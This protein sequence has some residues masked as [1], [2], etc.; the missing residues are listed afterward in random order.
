MSIQ[1]SEISEKHSSLR[2]RVELR[3]IPEPNSGCWLWE[4]IVSKDGY[5]IL[6]VRTLTGQTKRVRAHRVAW[7]LEN[8]PIPVGVLACHRCDNR[9]CVNPDHIFLGSPSDNIRDMV[10]KGREGPGAFAPGNSHRLAKL[11]EQDVIEIR[12]SHEKQSVLASRYGVH[13]SNISLLQNGRIWKHLKQK[14]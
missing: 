11:S 5:G 7:E 10:R 9:C 6:Q 2:E 4:G 1:I 12:R 14:D 3:T 13:Q 8:G